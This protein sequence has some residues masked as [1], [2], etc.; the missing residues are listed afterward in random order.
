V[1]RDENLQAHAQEVGEHVLAGL[2]SLA[3]R[4]AIV[5]DVR[6][7]GF[8]VGV[9][10]VRDRESLEPAGEEAA[11]V[12]ERMRERGVLLGTDGP[13]HNVVKIRPPMPFDRADADLLVEA[14]DESLRDL[15]SSDGE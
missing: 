12:A 2:R 15:P 3:G 4:H 6:G 8:F 13:F 5:G 11:F 14:L 7:S 9:E 1:V 10:L